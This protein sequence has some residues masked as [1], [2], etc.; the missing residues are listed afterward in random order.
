[1]PEFIFCGRRGTPDPS[2][3]KAELQEQR[4]CIPKD[5]RIVA[6]SILGGLHHEYRLEEIGA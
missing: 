5:C 4:H 6:K 2:S 3:L 1:M